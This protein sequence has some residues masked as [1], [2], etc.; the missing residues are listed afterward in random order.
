M[1]RIQFS[2][3][4]GLSCFFFWAKVVA[5][6]PANGIRKEGLGTRTE[7]H[8]SNLHKIPLE[9]RN[10]NGRKMQGSNVEKESKMK[11]KMSTQ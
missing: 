9:K 8:E 2:K 3:K 7:L 1:A 4:K 10:K 5:F 11:G 6:A